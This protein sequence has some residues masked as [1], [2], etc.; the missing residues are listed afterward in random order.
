MEWLL[1]V[2]T[3]KI[4]DSKID[5]RA[6]SSLLCICIIIKNAGKSRKIPSQLQANKAINNEVDNITVL[7]EIPRGGKG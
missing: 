1:T 4:I 7:K 6:R 5:K 3:A 2:L